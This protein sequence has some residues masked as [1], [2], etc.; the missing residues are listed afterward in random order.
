MGGIR[1]NKTGAAL[2]LLLLAVSLAGCGSTANG[3]AA[4]GEK[5]TLTISI[6]GEGTVSPTSGLTYTKGTVV[7]LVPSPGTGWTF[8]QWGG[9]DGTSVV[10]DKILMDRNRSITAVFVSSG[11]N[12]RP[13]VSLEASSTFSTNLPINIMFTA[14]ATDPDGDALTYSWDFGDGTPTSG[15]AAETHTY[16]FPGPYVAKVTVADSKG[17]VA[18]S[19]VNLS[20]PGVIATA[21]LPSRAE[22]L[23]VVDNLVYVADGTSGLRVLDVTDPR[24]PVQVDSVDTDGTCRDVLVY[25][26]VAYVADATGGLKIVSLSPFCQVVT[27][28]RDGSAH[29][30]CVD[31]NYLYVAVGRE[32]GLPRLVVY[33]LADPVNPVK[34]GDVRLW[35]YSNPEHVTVAGRYAYVSS[36]YNARLHVVDISNP[37]SPILISETPLSGVT[38]ANELVVRGL[39]LHMATMYKKLMV[40]DLTYP[41]SPAILTSVGDPGNADCHG[42]YLDGDFAYIAGGGMSLLDISVPS[43]PVLKGSIYNFGSSDVAVQGEY[44]YLVGDAFG[45][46]YVGDPRSWR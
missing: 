2:A 44:A 46:V 15:S 11:A 18:E 17:G 21:A 31:G 10:E 19:S 30:L 41:T 28:L 3:P 13:V 9:A 33:S 8:E 6:Q 4:S 26:N 5:Y 43:N 14:T 22:S 40:A 38:T 23:V 12:H 37:S 25:G 45:V 42:L 34:L 20:F 29:G 7:T 16:T 24:H 27:T 35:D 1:M 32:T 36:G 39:N